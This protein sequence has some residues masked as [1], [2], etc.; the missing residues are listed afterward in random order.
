MA[1]PKKDQRPGRCSCGLVVE[2]NSAFCIECGRL[3]E[4]GA[5]QEVLARWLYGHD[6]YLVFMESVRAERARRAA[7]P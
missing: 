2:A 4:L 6:D 5:R 7:K 3:I 1:I